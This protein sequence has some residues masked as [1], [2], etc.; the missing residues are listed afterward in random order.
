MVDESFHSRKSARLKEYHYFVSINTFDPFKANYLY[1]F[2]DRIDLSKIREAME[3][4][5]GTHDFRSFSKNKTISSCIRTITK[6]DLIIKD[7][8]LEFV[9]IGSGF[10][11]NMVRIIIALMLKVGEGK[12]QPS[13]IGKII[14]GKQRRLALMLL[15]R[16]VFIYGRY[17]INKKNANETNSI[18]AFLLFLGLFFFLLII[19][20]L[21]YNYQYGLLFKVIIGID[22]F[23]S[24]FSIIIKF[25][26]ISL[27][28]GLG[29]LN[30]CL[31]IFSPQLY[32]VL[33][34]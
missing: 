16:V 5:V 11:Y 26:F 6:F 7:G 33:R 12:L 21:Y 3:Y 29:L 2:H 31:F 19:H 10:M 23:F 13:D 8:I 14:E 9:I 15:L 18:C 27:L 24:K 20:H 34:F 32:F 4:I 1:F 22:K 25:F 28:K 30:S 17:I